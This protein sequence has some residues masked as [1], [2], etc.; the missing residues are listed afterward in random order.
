KELLERIHQ[1]AGG[2]IKLGLQPGDNVVL[3]INNTAEFYFS[4]FAL[5]FKG[6]KP[7]LALPAHRYLELSYF[8]DHAR[9]RAYIF[10][11][12]ASGETAQNIASQLL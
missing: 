7:V 12:H 3:Q 4:F 1:L 11:E 5:T 9:A 8:C 2:F 6:I 10:S